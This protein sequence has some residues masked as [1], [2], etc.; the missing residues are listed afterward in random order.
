[1]QLFVILVTNSRDDLEVSAF[2]LYKAAESVFILW[3][4]LQLRR[5]QKQAENMAAGDLDSKIDTKG[6]LWDLKRHGEN[7]NQL[8]DGMVRAVDAR[9]KSERFKTELITNVSHDIKTPLTSIINYV[10][11]LK[12]EQLG[13]EKAQ[14]YLEVLDR[15]SLRMKKL[16]ED[17]MD[18]SKASTGNL[19]VEKELCDVNIL[20]TQTLGE[21]EERLQQKDLKLI[22]NKEESPIYLFVDNR[23][24]WR[25]FDNL[26]NNI[27]KYGQSG[28]RVY[29]NIEKNQEKADIIFRNTSKYPL[30]ISSEELMERFIRGDASRNTEGSGLGLSI[31]Q[32]LCRLMD[33]S[34]KLYVDGDLFKVVLTFPQF[35]E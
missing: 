31:A 16:I 18:A 11:L 33:G 24:L 34:M 5:L 2:L 30:N 4:V 35:Q 21:F 22:I 15:Q 1:M 28:T 25:I 19:T 23:Y 3:V 32:D 14:E 7:L 6:L 12:K 29:I 27:C 9:M 10:D 8:S 13:N 26:M 17:L 20:L